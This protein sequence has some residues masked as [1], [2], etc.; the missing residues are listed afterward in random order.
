MRWLAPYTVV[1]V[2]VGAVGLFAGHRWQQP[3]IDALEAQV[4][5]QARSIAALTLS[6][7]QSVEARRVEATRAQAAQAAIADRDA[8]I[9]A[10]L[11]ADLGDCADAP[12]DP[13]L[14]DLLRGV[15]P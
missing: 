15:H 13:E 6:R 8:R 3:A 5:S 10:L 12:L 4:A 1:G 11:T 7:D 14:V 2:L 9:E